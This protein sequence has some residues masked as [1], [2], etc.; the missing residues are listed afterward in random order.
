[1]VIRNV[2]SDG[3]QPGRKAI[4]VT[5]ELRSFAPGFLEGGS[6]QVFSGSRISNPVAEEVVEARDVICVQSV[7]VQG[8]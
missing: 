4:R 3:E 7:P 5:A 8:Q 2:A 6:G 1:M